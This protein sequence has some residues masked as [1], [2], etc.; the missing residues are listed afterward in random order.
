MP[1][2]DAARAREVWTYDPVT[3]VLRWRTKVAMKIVVGS[4][5]GSPNADGHLRIKLAGKEYYAH[6]IAWLM[7]SGSWPA[8]TIDHINGVRDDNRLVNLREASRFQQVCNRV[9]QRNNAQ[10]LKGVHFAKREGRYRATIRRNGRC[11]HLGLFDTPEEA[12]AA[13]AA[14]AASLHGEF[15]R[16]S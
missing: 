14:A 9:A 15:A 3:G 8:E 12:H 10:G 2:L 16:A 11:R 1:D 5:A 7:T 6:R 4:V 13:Y